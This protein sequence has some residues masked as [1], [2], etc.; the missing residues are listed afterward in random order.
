[1]TPHEKAANGRYMLVKNFSILDDEFADGEIH[2][3][4]NF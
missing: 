4:K 2:A 3:F 1:M